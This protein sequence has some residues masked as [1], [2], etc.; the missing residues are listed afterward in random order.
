MHVIYS[1]EDDRVD[2]DEVK[3]FFST[4]PDSITVT[5]WKGDHYSVADIARSGLV[6]DWIDQLPRRGQEA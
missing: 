3:E 2:A 4:H 1:D 6:L 5:R